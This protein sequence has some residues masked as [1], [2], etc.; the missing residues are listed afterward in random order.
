[1]RLSKLSLGPALHPWVFTK[2]SLFPLYPSPVL[3]RMPCDIPGWSTRAA[4]SHEW[5]RLWLACFH[6]WTRLWLAQNHKWTRLWSVCSH[7]WPRLWST[8]L[9]IMTRFISINKI[10]LYVL[11]QSMIS[12]FLYW[13]VLCVL[14][15]FAMS[16]VLMFR[17]LNKFFLCCGEG[18]RSYSPS[19][20]VFG[21]C[22]CRGRESAFCTDFLAFSSRGIVGL[23]TLEVFDLKY[24]MYDVSLMKIQWSF[25]KNDSSMKYSQF[26]RCFWSQ[27]VD[28]LVVA[29]LVF[30]CVDKT[31]AKMTN[32]PSKG[33]WLS[34][35]PYHTLLN[36]I[37]WS[38]SKKDENFRLKAETFI[39]FTC[40][41]ILSFVSTL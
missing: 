38:F 29:C 35:T 11:W 1:M 36:D 39:A 23:N 37:F 32:L 5:S 13:R 21:L 41:R 26:C 4:W 12:T 6:K 24:T 8:S 27:G 33:A 2:L 10:M 18:S 16:L 34:T 17:L 14:K 31:L 30:Y 22:P 19:Y 40:F 15:V 7:E 3:L 25:G 28:Q 9:L 20:S